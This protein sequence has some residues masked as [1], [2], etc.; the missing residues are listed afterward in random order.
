MNAPDR[1]QWLAERQSGV[2]GTDSPVILGLSPFKTAYALWLEKTGRAHD[3]EPDEDAAERM[4][5]GQVLEDVVAREHSARTGSKLQRINSLLRHPSSPV[6][7]ANIDRAIVVDGSRA[8]WDDKAGRLVGARGVLECKTA[9]ALARNGADWG[10]PGTDEVPR[11]YWVQCQHYLGVTGL[12]YADLAVLFGGQKFVVYTIEAD[13]AL[14]ADLMTEVDAWWRRHVVADI[15]PDP[16]T[17]SDARALWRSHVAGREKVVDVLVADAVQ[18]LADA[19]AQIAELEREAQELRDTITCAFGDAESI[20][21]MGRRLATWKANKPSSKT[22]WKAAYE[23]ARVALHAV[24]TA[25]VQSFPDYPP[26]VRESVL[27]DRLRDTFTTT[28]DGARVLR[29]NTKEL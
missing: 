10:E 24:N 25:W 29:L 18:Q 15:P 8:R 21:Y 7:L 27:S 12:P 16:T 26:P 11:N 6:M 20:S 3:E 9:Q 4:H 22:N 23:D 28:T 19:K 17:E 13:P 1:A 5:F 2:G 14:F